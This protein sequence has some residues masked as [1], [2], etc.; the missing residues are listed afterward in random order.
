[1]TARLLFAI[2]A[3]APA[4]LFAQEKEEK[5][6]EEKKPAATEEEST[7]LAPGHSQHGEVFNQGPR[8]AAVL[9]EGT[10]DID[11]EITTESEEAQKFFNQ[12][13]GQLHGFWTLEA[14]RSFRQVAAI[15]PECAMAYWGMGMANLGNK[16]RGKG[17]AEK[18]VERKD[19]AS[20]REQKWIDA[21]SK[22]FADGDDKKLRRDFVRALENLTYDYPDDI[23]A[24]AFL[25]KQIYANKS[26]HPIPSH[27]AVDL[28]IKGCWIR[29]R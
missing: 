18:A 29:W 19:Q 25:M 12:G 6:D 15:D 27:M 2:L 17:F 24:K 21:L 4:F 28:L 11:F 13:V 8:Q 22:Y 1:M 5:K 9:I 23:E 26:K 20:E 10:G 7:E 14:E 3:F 16:K